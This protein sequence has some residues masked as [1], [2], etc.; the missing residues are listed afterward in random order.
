MWEPYL[1]LASLTFL[2]GQVTR[3]LLTC[4]SCIIPLASVGIESALFFLLRLNLAW[5][6][7][8]I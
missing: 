7:L 6:S 1:V 8:Q 3:V 5:R 4:V 2:C